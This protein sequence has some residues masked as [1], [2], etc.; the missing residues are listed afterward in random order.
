MVGRPNASFSTTLAFETALEDDLRRHGF[1][2]DGTH[3][4]SQV[5]LALMVSRE[6]LPVSYEAPP[7]ATCEGHSLV[8]V[9]RDMRQ[10][11]RVE[12][13]VCVADRGMPGADNLDAMDAMGNG[14]MVGARLRKLPVA[15]HKQVLD[16]DAYGPLKG[17]DGRRVGEWEHKGRRLIVVR[18]PRRARKDARERRK[19]VARLLDK[20]A[21]GSHPK[22]LLSHHGA[23]RF[24][25]VQ[26]DARLTVN[27]EKIAEAERWDGLS[28]VITNLRDAAATEVL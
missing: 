15:L 19:V 23:K 2:K 27:P 7:G 21:R 8:P 3:R 17:A 28:G 16:P 5:L 25:A 4:G 6:G 24:I 22:A 12:R 18:C 1:S 10:R 20:L 13:A 9:P 26:G 11:H 14:Y